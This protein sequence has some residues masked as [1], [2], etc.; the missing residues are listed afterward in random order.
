MKFNDLCKL[1]KITNNKDDALSIKLFFETLKSG[2]ISEELGKITYTK[3]VALSRPMLKD[4]YVLNTQLKNNNVS[5]NKYTQISGLDTFFFTL[6]S[7]RYMYRTEKDKKNNFTD[8]YTQLNKSYR[9]LTVL[10]CIGLD[11]DNTTLTLDEVK[12]AVN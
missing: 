3:L 5:M 1:R 2:E 9:N 10:N 6:N 12:E 4:D 8:N 7:F 11:I